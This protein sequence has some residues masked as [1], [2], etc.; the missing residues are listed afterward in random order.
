L[1]QLSVS[2]ASGQKTCSSPRS[3]FGGQHA[4]HSAVFVLEK[5]PHRSREDDHART[6]V[7]EN[8]GFHIAVQFLAVS[9]V[10]FAIHRDEG[11][12]QRCFH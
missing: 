1:Y 4:D 10:I 11:K 2:T 12:A 9:F 3:I 8:Q 6:R 5:S 7:P